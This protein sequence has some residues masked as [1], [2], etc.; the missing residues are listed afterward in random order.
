LIPITII[1]KLVILIL[2]SF[3]LWEE[4]IQGICF[5]LNLS[6]MINLNLKSILVSIMDFRVNFWVVRDY[7]YILQGIYVFFFPGQNKVENRF[8]LV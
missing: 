5:F 8:F 7:E 3:F 2:M 6:E 4:F 1:K